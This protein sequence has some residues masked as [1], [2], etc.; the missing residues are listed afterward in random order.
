MAELAIGIAELCRRSDGLLGWYTTTLWLGWPLVCYAAV[1]W[2]GLVVLLGCPI[3]GLA[4]AL[5]CSFR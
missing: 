3:I 1:W 4:S 5:P 2:Q